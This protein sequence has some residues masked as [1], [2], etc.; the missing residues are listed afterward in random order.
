MPVAAQPDEHLPSA[1]QCHGW[2]RMFASGGFT[3]TDLAG[4]KRWRTMSGGK[5]FSGCPAWYI[6]AI[7]CFKN[8]CS[9]SNATGYCNNHPVMAGRNIDSSVNFYRL[10]KFCL[11][12]LYTEFSSVWV[13]ELIIWWIILFY[14]AEWILPSSPAVAG[15]SGGGPADRGRVIRTPAYCIVE[16]GLRC[17]GWIVFR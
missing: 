12:N 5:G 11:L 15:C 7:R 8:G 1:G 14:R 4:D 3:A 17:Q 2:W 16:C 6:R 13:H 10:I 9:V